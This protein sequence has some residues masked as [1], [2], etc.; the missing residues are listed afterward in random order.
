M[1]CPHQKYNIEPSLYSPYFSLG[2]CMEGLNS[3]FTQLYGVTHA[4]VHETEGLLGYIYCDFFHRVNKP[5]QDCHF[6]IRG[7]R[8]FQ[9]NGQ[10]QLPVV[11]LML[12]LPHP[13]KSTPTL[14]MP[15][16]MENLV[17]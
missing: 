12:S 3:L 5:H 13:T 15:D 6:T 9:E 11:V 1:L 10:Y 17:H 16:M 7:G 14:L 8:Q 2:S 4:V